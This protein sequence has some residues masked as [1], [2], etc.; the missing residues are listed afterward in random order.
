MN[1]RETAILRREEIND[2]PF[3][4]QVYAHTRVEELALTNWD[5]ATRQ[6]FLTMQFQAMRRG[7]GEVV[8]D[9]G[10]AIAPTLLVPIDVR[11]RVQLPQRLLAC[12]A[13]EAVAAVRG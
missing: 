5:P 1:T 3:L 4:F 9:E 10:V 11:L 7:V 2:E 8:A 13:E 12:E 6:A